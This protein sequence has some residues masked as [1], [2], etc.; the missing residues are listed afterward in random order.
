MN[1]LE[2]QTFLSTKQCINA[3]N[4]DGGGSTTMWLKGRGVVN[5]P[6][7][8]FGERKVANALLVIQK[9]R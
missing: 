7:D 6:S 4:L 8:I 3:I 9:G 2:L 1:L 5:T